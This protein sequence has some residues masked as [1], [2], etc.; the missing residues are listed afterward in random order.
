MLTTFEEEKFKAKPLRAGAVGYL[1]RD[2]PA[3]Q[4]ARAIQLAHAG[5]CELEPA[6]AG[7]WSMLGGLPERPFNACGRAARKRSY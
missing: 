2:I 5:I 1:L 3:S 7:N 4:L 6:V